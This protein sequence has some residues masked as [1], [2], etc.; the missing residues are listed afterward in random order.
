MG[1]L[2]WITGAGKAGETI[3]KVGDG[4]IKGLDMLVLTKEEE[5]QYKAAAGELWLKTQGVLATENTARTLTRRYISIAV[6]YSWLMMVM[7]SFLLALWET[8][9][10]GGIVNAIQLFTVVNQVMG[11]IVLA[12]VVFYFGPS[13]LGRVIGEVK[14]EK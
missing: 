1:L 13:A 6:M 8:V 11:T 5:V 4:I 2:S 9:T 3:D 12:I 14:K 10:N 7:S